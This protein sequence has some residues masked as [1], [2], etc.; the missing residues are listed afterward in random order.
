LLGKNYTIFNGKLLLILLNQKVEFLK[1]IFVISGVSGAGK[2]TLINK[3]MS[4]FSKEIT[5]VVS[6]TTRP[7]RKSEI[8]G[9][10]YHFVNQE[11]FSDMISNNMFIEHIQFF[12]NYYGTAITS[13]QQSLLVNNSCVMDIEWDGAYKILHQDILEKNMQENVRKI[14]ILILPPS[15]KSLHKRLLTRN[16]ETNQSLKVR[17]TQSFAIKNIARYDNIIVNS[18]L[19][20]AYAELK[21][22]YLLWK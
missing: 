14:G 6:H 19:D 5:T 15:I 13:I 22:I 10:D 7:P 9:V 3:L 18:L 8:N 4:E 12:D 17:L 11:I 2:S 16:S 20:D 21:R 1:N